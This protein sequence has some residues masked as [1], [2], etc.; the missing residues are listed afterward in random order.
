VKKINDLTVSYEDKMK[1]MQVSLINEK[2]DQAQSDI[3]GSVDVDKKNLEKSIEDS[4]ATISELKNN[5]AAEHL[6][7]EEEKLNKLIGDLQR[8]LEPYENLLRQIDEQRK[9]ALEQVELQD[10]EMVTA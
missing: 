8:I 10:S 9:Q 5:G 7:I 4:K 2:F 3:L 1:Y 6:K